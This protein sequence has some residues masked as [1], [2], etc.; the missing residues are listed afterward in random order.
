MFASALATSSSSPAV[1]RWDRDDGR[2]GIVIAPCGDSL[3]G[4]IV[5]LK[6]AAGPGHVGERV[7]FGMKR[8]GVDTWAGTAHNP[9]D[10]QDYSGTMTVAGNRLQTR[11]CMLGGL[12]CKSVGLFRAR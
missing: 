4:H 9:E 10:G 6:E 12:L 2:G 5:W 8:T 11:G 7:L 1:G 3:C